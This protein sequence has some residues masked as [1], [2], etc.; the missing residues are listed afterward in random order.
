MVPLKAVF[1]DGFPQVRP[2]VLL[3]GDRS[4]FPDRHCNPIDGTLCLLGRDSRQWVPAL[5]LR[6]LLEEKL[7]DALKGTGEEDAQGEPAEVYWNFCGTRDSYCLIDSSWVLEDATAGTLRIRYSLSGATKPPVVKSVVVEV[8]DAL[9]HG[10]CQWRSSLPRELASKTCPEVT[11]PWVRVRES[12]LPYG[13]GVADQLAAMWQKEEHFRKYNPIKFGPDLY[14]LWFAFAYDA[15]LAWQQNGLSWLFVF[16]Y[17][18]KQAFAKDSKT[19]VWTSIIRTYRAGESLDIGSRVPAVT[20]LRTSSV[21]VFGLGAIGAPVAV[22]LARNGC[23]R[24]HLIDRDVVEPGNGIRWPLGASVWGR[25]KVVALRDFLRDEYP[26]AEVV[27]HEHPIGSFSGGDPL[28][29][30][31]IGD[32]EILEAVL[33]D[34]TLVV[35]A[36]ASYGVTTLLSDWCRRRGIPLIASYA[37]PTVQ[38]GVVARFA[39]AGGCPVCLEHSWHTNVIQRPPGMNEDPT[40]QPPGCAERT[41][42]GADFDLQE[43]SLQTMRLVVDTLSEAEKKD[44]SLVQTLS[45]TDG[46]G[47]RS[48][49][50]WHV[51]ALPVHPRCTCQQRQ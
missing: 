39:P 1:P 24:L 6:Q 5:T 9:K 29:G 48:M 51:D 14:A 42:M 50:R 37:S 46:A 36:T 8:R 10:I 3:L 47:R 25:E 26:W 35:D 43:L 38:G 28:T 19:G 49:P 18:P 41:F 11:I 13:T 15:N 45:F 44:S 31:A 40:V 22:D 23:R 27:P 2:T 30:S 20:H 17:G 21:A 7:E 4:A 12:L 32:K 33:G 16:V 34:V